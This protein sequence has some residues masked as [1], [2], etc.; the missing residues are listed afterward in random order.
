MSLFIACKRQRVRTRA[1]RVC[2]VMVL[3]SQPIRG[4]IL[5]CR[6]R[7]GQLQVSGAQEDDS[8]V[9]RAG[10]GGLGAAAADC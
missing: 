10:V 4:V 1:S 9:I 3:R 6:Q 7:G 8:G 5:F 2:Q